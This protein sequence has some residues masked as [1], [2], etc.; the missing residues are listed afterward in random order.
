MEVPT[1]DSN[2]T[3]DTPQ[4]RTLARTIT[5]AKHHTESVLF[6]SNVNDSNGKKNYITG[7]STFLQ[8]DVSENSNNVNSNNCDDERFCDNSMNLS[9]KETRWE[10]ITHKS[11]K[12]KASNANRTF[13]QALA[14]GTSPGSNQIGQTIQPS[15]NR[16]RPTRRSIVIV[17]SGNS[18]GS[19]VGTK[20]AWFHIGKVSKDTNAEVIKDFVKKEFSLSDVNVE[21]L[22]SKGQNSSFRLGVDFSAKDQIMKS[23]VWPKN[24]TIKRVLFP[25]RPE[26][27]IK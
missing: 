13:V 7:G 2:K 18:S 10:T 27:K 4:P 15:V 1:L 9:E 22:E 17:G 8:S 25:R 11:K 14:Q 23:I 26:N 16:P 20:R 19:F 5:Q 3:I 21:K 24:V 6:T 12:G